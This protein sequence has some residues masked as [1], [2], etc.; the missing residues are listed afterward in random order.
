MGKHYIER[1]IRRN[2][3]WKSHIDYKSDRIENVII[4]KAQMESKLDRKSPM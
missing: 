3:L 2:V 1:R 4:L